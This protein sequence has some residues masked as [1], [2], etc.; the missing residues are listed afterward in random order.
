MKTALILSTLAL[1]LAMP[2]MAQETPQGTAET[3]SASA[4]ATAKAGDTVYDT[5]GEVVGTVE[6][7]TS[8]NF[9]I[10]T[11]TNK[12]TLPL[13]VLANGA[14]GPTIGMSKNQLDAEIQKATQ[15]N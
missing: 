11:G 12:A 10:S 5:T 9:V 13:S 15:A 1:G 7:V 8:D 14:K 6:S 3:P 4:E 2:A